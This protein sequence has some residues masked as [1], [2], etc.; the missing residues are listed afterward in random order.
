MYCFH[1]CHPIK[2]PGPELPQIC[3]V[4]LQ[5]RKKCHWILLWV[6][7]KVIFCISRH[8]LR[9]SHLHLVHCS[10]GHIYHFRPVSLRS[11][12]N[13]PTSQD[14]AYFLVSFSTP[15]T[16]M[17]WNYRKVLLF[18]DSGN[19]HGNICLYLLKYPICE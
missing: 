15:L 5:R 19:S 8:I 3:L 12:E 14:L 18:T 11:A 10:R 9:R 7:F 17:D 16:Q 1:Y 6:H 4:C 13:W 2:I